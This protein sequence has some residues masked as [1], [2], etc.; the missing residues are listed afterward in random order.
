LFVDFELGKV[1]ILAM[2]LCYVQ[3]IRLIFMIIPFMIVIVFFVVV[4]ASGLGSQRD[5]SD[6]DWGHK[7][8]A[9]HGRIPETGHRLSPGGR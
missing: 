8:G 1:A 5:W 3:A 7:G 6:C 4:G 2:V 9:Q